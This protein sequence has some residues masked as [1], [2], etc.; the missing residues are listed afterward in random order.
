M[1][2]IKRNIDINDN[3]LSVK[4]ENLRTPTLRIKFIN[5]N[6]KKEQADQPALKP[7]SRNSDFD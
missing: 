7:I 6:D 2:K 4:K 3:R 5:I 1:F